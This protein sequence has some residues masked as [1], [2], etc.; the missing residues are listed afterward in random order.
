MH[1]VRTIK[2][3]IEKERASEKDHREF[4]WPFLAKFQKGRQRERLRDKERERERERERESGRER[5]K[6][7]ERLH[8]C[9]VQNT[10]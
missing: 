6:E 8:D 5:E 9:S 4:K 7:G 10:G 2:S 3:K 1:N